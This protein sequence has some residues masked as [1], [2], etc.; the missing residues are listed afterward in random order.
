MNAH[1]TLWFAALVASVGVATAV[2]QENPAAAL[3][4][5]APLAAAPRVP[6]DLSERLAEIRKKSDVPAIAAV[7]LDRHGVMARGVTGMRR[8]GGSTPVTLDDRWHLGSCTKAMTATLC[9]LLVNDGKL[10]WDSSIDDV[11]N[12]GRDEKAKITNNWRLVT[13]R[14]LT[15]CTANVPYD[16]GQYGGRPLWKYL[17]EK[18]RQ[19]ASPQEQRAYLFNELVRNNIGTPPG[20]FQYANASL[21]LAGYMAETAGGMPY[22]QLVQER[23]FHPLGIT[24]AGFGSPGTGTSDDEP[25]DQPWGHTS[26]GVP[27]R[28]GINADNPSAIAPAGKAYMTIEDW[29]RFARL[30]LIGAEISLPHPIDP[31][32]DEVEPWYDPSETLGLG[33]ADFAVLHA[34]GNDRNTDYAAGWIVTNRPA[35]A[36]GDQ[37]GATG[38][39]LTHT[40]SNT[41]WTAA[42]WIAP[43][44]DR[45]FLAVVN[46]TKEAVADDAREQALQAMIALDREWRGLPP[47]KP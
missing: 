20:G 43:E 11:F 46:S 26:K 31:T 47:M 28:P 32:N 2:A 24:S 23:L 36:K 35:W 8:A 44:I 1:R 3:Q 15:T 19:G 33:P 27:V 14:Q 13:L 30:H 29:G 4:P 41:M 16:L 42:I 37:P 9:A 18:A 10:Q 21:A 7:M 22:E 17:W 5:P 25:E 38:R 45:A 39:C 40:G 6:V 12:A 34:Q